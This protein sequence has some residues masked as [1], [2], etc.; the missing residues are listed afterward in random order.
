MM[1]TAT[2]HTR[3]DATI[4]IWKRSNDSIGIQMRKERKK[5]RSARVSGRNARFHDM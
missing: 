3:D 4:S 5:I 1:A 2:Q